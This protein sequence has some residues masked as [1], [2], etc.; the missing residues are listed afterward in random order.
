[1]FVLRQSSFSTVIQLEFHLNHNKSV[2]Y[3]SSLSSTVHWGFSSY[4]PTT[5]THTIACCVP[6]SLVW[7][8][9]SGSQCA[10]PSQWQAV[11]PSEKTPDLKRALRT[12]LSKMKVK[13]MRL[14][15][16]ALPL[17]EQKHL[18]FCVVLHTCSRSIPIQHL[19]LSITSLC[20]F[21]HVQNSACI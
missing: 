19:V 4:Y 10:F 11:S 7:K 16:K 20:L 15:L 21:K 13:L 2:L 18:S 3:S 1:M 14:A 9:L 5:H 12:L 6:V 8:P 17:L